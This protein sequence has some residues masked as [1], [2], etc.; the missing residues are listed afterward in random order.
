[1]LSIELWPM[2]R[3]GMWEGSG[4]VI[5]VLC[6]SH[7]EQRRVLPHKLRHR[8]YSWLAC[9]AAAAAPSISAICAAAAATTISGAATAPATLLPS[10]PA[11]S[12]PAI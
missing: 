1:M 2:R 4:W 3:L 12:M 8:V 6:C 11:P 10:D 5:A 9:I 7:R